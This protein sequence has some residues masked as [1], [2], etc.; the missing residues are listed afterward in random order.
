MGQLVDHLLGLW[1]WTVDNGLVLVIT[2]NFMVLACAIGLGCCVAAISL[3]LKRQALAL[4][5]NEASLNILRQDVRACALSQSHVLSSV[6]EMRQTIRSTG[7]ETDGDHALDRRT[8]SL[9]R[10]NIQSLLRDISD[11]GGGSAG[12]PQP[13]SLSERAVVPSA[14]LTD[15]NLQN[16]AP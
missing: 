16:S 8:A 12:E 7:S 3:R 2:V 6:D 15:D 4:E 10:E 14:Q 11:T 13:G 1:N 5:K 9:I